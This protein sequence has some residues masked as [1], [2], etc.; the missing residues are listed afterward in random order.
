MCSLLTTLPASSNL[1]NISFH[2][3]LF[4]LLENE[5]CVSVLW[6]CF[7]FQQR[8][9]ALFMHIP[10]WGPWVYPPGHP[11]LALCWWWI[12][13]ATEK[14]TWGRGGWQ[15]SS[16]PWQIHLSSPG[17][18][19]DKMVIPG[20]GRGTAGSYLGNSMSQCNKSIS[21][22]RIPFL[23]VVPSLRQPCGVISCTA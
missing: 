10:T 22:G 16:S 2:H 5:N 7:C 8:N 23:H 15:P 21:R 11:H 13:A 4:S 18:H 14:S 1:I 9:P 19:L 6:N 20:C 12:T 17:L 3:A